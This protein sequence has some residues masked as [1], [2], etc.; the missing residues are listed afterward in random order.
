MWFKKGELDSAAA[1]ASADERQHSGKDT[2]DKAD[3]LPIDERY[4]D[5]GSI[6]RGDKEKYSLRTGGTQMMPS[7]K[8]G[9]AASGKVSEDS[10][11]DE[12]KGGRN[13]ILI[14]LGVGLAILVAIIVIATR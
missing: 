8:D 11:I 4:T 13:K 6:T 10:L 5:D 12:M 1:Q 7:V 2:G 9:P 14:A 3:S